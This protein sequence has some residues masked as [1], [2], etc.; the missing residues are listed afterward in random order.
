[1]GKMIDAQSIVVAVAA[2]YEDRNEG[3]LAV[4]PIFRG[5][6]PHSLALAILMGMLVWLQAYV[7]PWM[8]P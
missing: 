2:C 4:G 6:F 7:W 5:V 3:K 8:V 1:M